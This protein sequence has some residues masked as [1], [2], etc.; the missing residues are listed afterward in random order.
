MAVFVLLSVQTA[1]TQ[2]FDK[3]EEAFNQSYTKENAGEYDRAIDVLKKVYDDK[4]YALNIRLGW[5]Y[6]LSGRFTDGLAYYQKAIRLMPQSIEARLGLVYPAS[7]LGNWEQVKNAYL[8]ILKIDPGH[9]ITNY[10][11]GL[12][13][14]GR[15]Q[16]ATAIRYFE[17]VANYYP[18]DYDANLMYGWTCLKLGKYRE[19]RILFNNALMVKP[20][21]KS[22][23]EGLSF[24]K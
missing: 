4:S 3:L 12:I 13:Y 7:A 22:A 19:A 14:Y 15:E 8:E 11:L 2:N 23:K 21:D 17:K 18:F 10:R 1:Y 9:S 6:Y 20:G 5:L 24:I 16:Y